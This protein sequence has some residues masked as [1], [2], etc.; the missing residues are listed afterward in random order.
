MKVLREP[1]R[2]EAQS[3]PQ[4]QLVGAFAGIT[5]LPGRFEPHDGIGS[6]LLELRRSIMERWARYVE[7]GAAAPDCGG[8]GLPAGSKRPRSARRRR[9][10]AVA[11]LA[12]GEVVFEQPSLF[13]NM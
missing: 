8:R 10:K 4:P 7:A 6:Q 5:C 9:R 12:D 2:S 13:V 11:A 3:R 1:L